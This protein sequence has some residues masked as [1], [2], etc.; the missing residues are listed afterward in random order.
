[1]PPQTQNKDRSTQDSNRSSPNPG[2]STRP[3]TRRTGPPVMLEEQQDIRDALDGRKFLEKCS[4]LC[5]PGEPSTHQSLAICL[6]QIS[7]MAGIP[8]QMINAIRS[9]AFLLDELEDIQINTTLH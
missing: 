4:L 2:P 8:K 1:M 6:H 5:P 7:V 3:N 9:V